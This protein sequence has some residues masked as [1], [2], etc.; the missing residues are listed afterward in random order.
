MALDAGPVAAGTE[1]CLIRR[2]APDI[3]DIDDERIPADRIPDALRGWVTSLGCP[4]QS[5]R[6]LSALER[7]RIDGGFDAEYRREAMTALAVGAPVCGRDAAQSD[8][9]DLVLARDAC[10]LYVDGRVP[11]DVEDVRV[12]VSWEHYASH[13]YLFQ[14][15]LELLPPFHTT[16]NLDPR[17]IREPERLLR[18][19]AAYD[20]LTVSIEAPQVAPALVAQWLD[21][22]R[23]RWSDGALQAATYRAVCADRRDDE[24]YVDELVDGRSVT[25]ALAEYAR[26]LDRLGWSASD[27]ASEDA[28]WTSIR[29]TIDA[30]HARLCAL[31]D[32]DGE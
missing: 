31:A 29:R 5:R 23:A 20:H 28:G 10:P 1:V 22:W 9:A 13:W 30:E 25:R 8:L 27:R 7:Y 15:V 32:P 17:A 2:A 18:T 24:W 6:L 21:R 26:V 4:S 16:D 14:L 3:W 19:L 11:I 12:G